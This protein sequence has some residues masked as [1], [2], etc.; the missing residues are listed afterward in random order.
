[1]ACATH[2]VGPMRWLRALRV[3]S[4]PLSALP[5]WIGTA[6]ALPVSEWRWGVLGAFT[7]AVLLLHAAGNLFNDYFDFLSGADR[8]TEDDKGRPG[9]LL[10]R[11]R[12]APREVL[13]GALVCLALGSAAGACLLLWR[14]RGLL[15]FLA[16]GI[17]AL[18]AY[19][20]PP[21]SL[22]RRALGEPLI[23][24][25]FG[26]L[27]TTGAAYAQTGS[28]A[29][30][31]LA[32]SVPVGMAPAAVLAGNNLRDFDEDAAA[33]VLTLARLLSRRG[34]RLLY[35]GLIGGQTLGFA[36]FGL[37]TG[38]W[39]LLLAPAFLPLATGT[40]RRLRRGER[41]PDVDARTASFAT[42]LM[43]FV[44]LALVLQ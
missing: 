19:T 24:A 29:G 44:L 38:R 20:A 43:A 5:V 25:V 9:R 3:F 28:V 41:V 11:G 21:L 10:V 32:L 7:A 37:F 22:K 34:Q 12:M 36:L 2:Q 33:D 26:P 42:A 40:L 39:L 1:M 30:H 27:L 18:Y 8:R 14:G 35:A 13:T 23:F 4:F 16:P 17:L 31:M 15:W 6:A